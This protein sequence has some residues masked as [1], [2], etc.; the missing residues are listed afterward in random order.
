MFV[1]KVS[2]ILHYGAYK[3]DYGAIDI[4]GLVF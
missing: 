1:M 3:L 2:E 4:G